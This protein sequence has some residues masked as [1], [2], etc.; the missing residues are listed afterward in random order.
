VVLALV[1]FEVVVFEVAVKC[2]ATAPLS[3]GSEPV[4]GGDWVC[5]YMAWVR[6]ET[7]VGSDAMALWRHA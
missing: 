1:V 3:T 5:R 4:S 6:K 7:H 2:G